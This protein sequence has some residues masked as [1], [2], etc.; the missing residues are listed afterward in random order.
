MKFIINEYTHN[1]Q[2][3]WFNDIRQIRKQ[4]FNCLLTFDLRKI[5]TWF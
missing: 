3:L 4:E 5:N 1:F 2:R